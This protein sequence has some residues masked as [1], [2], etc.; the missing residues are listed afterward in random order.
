M[1]WVGLGFGVISQLFLLRGLAT[2]SIAGKQFRI[3]DLRSACRVSWENKGWDY[4]TQ[5]RLKVTSLEVPGT[6]REPLK[7]SSHATRFRV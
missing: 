1:A 4:T 3:L 6:C 7:S 5:K 2:I